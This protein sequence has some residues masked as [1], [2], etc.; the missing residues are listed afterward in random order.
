[1][2]RGAED[3]ARVG[4]GR[5]LRRGTLELSFLLESAGGG[6]KEPS[7]GERDTF[8]DAARA[9]DHIFWAIT[10]KLWGTCVLMAALQTNCIAEHANITPPY[11]C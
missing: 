10:H 8:R 5:A 2:Q 11:D 9:R 7:K 1:M 4:G 3:A 6:R